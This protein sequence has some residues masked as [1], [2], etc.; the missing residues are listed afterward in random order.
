MADARSFRRRPLSAA[1][2]ER[3]AV[4]LERDWRAG[5]DLARSIH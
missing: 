5:R 1:C 2:F 3:L 4:N